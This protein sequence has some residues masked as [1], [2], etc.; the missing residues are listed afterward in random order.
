LNGEAPGQNANLEF[1]PNGDI[2]RI[3]PILIMVTPLFFACG[4]EETGELS[5][6]TSNQDAAVKA[7]AA[8]TPPY[9]VVAGCAGCSFSMAGAE[10]CQ[11]AVEVEGTPFFVT[12]V[13]DDTH[14]MGLCE[15]KRDALIEGEIVDGKFAA[16]SFALKP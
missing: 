11:L 8:K 15:N 6:D 2:M 4:G 13:D 7:L 14:E 9:D 1:Q 10:G 16:T 3:Y 12:G 5:Y